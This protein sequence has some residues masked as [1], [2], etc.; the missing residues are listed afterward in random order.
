MFLEYNTALSEKYFH[1]GIQ[2][3]SMCIHGKTCLCLDIVKFHLEC[4]IGSAILIVQYAN[5]NSSCH[6]IQLVRKSLSQGLKKKKKKSRYLKAL[7][8]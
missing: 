7:K 1:D 6:E 8:E 5:C 4:C 3:M 2:L